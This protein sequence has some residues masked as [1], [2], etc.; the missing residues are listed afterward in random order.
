MLVSGAEGKYHLK[1]TA[2]TTAVIA[3]EL[4]A[5]QTATIRGQTGGIAWMYTGFG[6][7]FHV[8]A[9]TELKIDAVAVAAASGIAFRLESDATISG[10][11]QLE[12][13]PVTCR[14][15]AAGIG[16]SA[17]DCEQGEAVGSITLAGPIFV[18]TSGSTMALGS[19]KYAGSSLPAFLDAIFTAEGG[20][21]IFVASGELAVTHTLTIGLAMHVTISGDASMPAWDYTGSDAAITV[22]ADGFLTLNSLGLSG[23]SIVVDGGSLVVNNCMM[24]AQ[25][26]PQAGTEA[27]WSGVYTADR[28]CALANGPTGDSSCWAGS[29]DFEFCCPAITSPASVR[30]IATHP[31]AP[32]TT[33]SHRA[34]SAVCVFF[35]PAFSSTYYNS[36][37]IIYVG[38]SSFAIHFIY[39]I[40]HSFY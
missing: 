30:P 31:T 2:S 35:Q 14:G 38:F 34:N 40:I 37:I 25:A 26:G 23:R 17:L 7:A 6:A 33:L 15:L 8:G 19:L 11:P 10:T 4:V 20:I 13:G 18:T 1:L 29:F 9:G 16:L 21:Y 5:G 24:D 36:T 22:A 32:P 27:C 28:C 3:A 39:I 12:S